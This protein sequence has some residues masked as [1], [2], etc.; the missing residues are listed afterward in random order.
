MAIRTPKPKEDTICTECWKHIYQ[1]DRY[2]WAKGKNG[3]VN[4]VHEDCYKKMCE[5]KK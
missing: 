2:I 5:R 1:C 4:F 3:R